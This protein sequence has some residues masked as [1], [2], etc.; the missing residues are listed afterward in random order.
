MN[1]IY[2]G[3]FIVMEMKISCHLVCWLYLFY[4]GLLRY[5]N[6]HHPVTIASRMQGRNH[7]AHMC[8]P[9]N[10][11]LYHTAWVYPRHISEKQ[12]VFSCVCVKNVHIRFSFWVFHLLKLE[13][14]Q[15]SETSVSLF[16]LRL[17]LDLGLYPWLALNW[18]SS[19]SPI[20][21]ITLEGHHV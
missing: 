17:R 13:E 18:W 7:T 12:R 21:E 19:G 10:G 8:R 15:M 1:H 4:L 3:G 6:S 11:R 5:T 14:L 2:D 20:S 9:R 16:V